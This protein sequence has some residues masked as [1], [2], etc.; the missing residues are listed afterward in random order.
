MLDWIFC[1]S[2]SSLKKRIEAE[3]MTINWLTELIPIAHMMGSSTEDELKSQKERAER[4]L[5]KLQSNLQY[6][7]LKIKVNCPQCGRQLYGA[8]QDMIGDIGVCPKCKSEFTIEQKGNNS[9]E[10]LK[11]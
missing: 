3:K 9:K 5:S 10:G 1:I 8:T 4:R 2:E 11:E 6:K 7:L